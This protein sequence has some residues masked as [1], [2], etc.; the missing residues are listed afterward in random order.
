MFFT[1]LSRCGVILATFATFAFSQPA[2]DPNNIITNGTFDTDYTG[3]NWEPIHG[4]QGKAS[5]VDGK[6]V[7]EVITKGVIFW[8]VQL[9]RNNLTI[10]KGVTYV[11]KFD[12]KSE[13][14]RSMIF[15][16]EAADG[17]TS[18]NPNAGSTNPAKLTSTMQPFTSNFTMALATDKTARLTFSMGDIISKITFDNI[19]LI[20]STKVTAVQSRTAVRPESGNS[21]R[22]NADSRGLSFNVSDPTHFGFRIFSPSGRVV[23]DY[24]AFNQGS[25][26]DYQSLGI[27]VGTYIVQTLD[28]N[29]RFSKVFTVMP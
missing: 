24:A 28:G 19:C 22:I 3:W 23:A 16:I 4:V 9:R 13:P 5:V 29:Q 18:Y 10:E 7:C 26:I 11:F 14:D 1:H 8:E 17:H 12:A 2:D 6:L 21:L 25:R 15:G 20:D 27:S